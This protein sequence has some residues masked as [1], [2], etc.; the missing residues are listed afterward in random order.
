MVNAF[1]Y[2]T[3]VLLNRIYRPIFF[4]MRT[5]HMTAPGFPIPS[6]R[7]LS[8]DAYNQ[9]NLISNAKA[10]IQIIRLFGV[11]RRSGF[12]QKHIKHRGILFSFLK[13]RT[14]LRRWLICEKGYVDKCTQKKT[15]PRMF[16]LANMSI[17]S[18]VRYV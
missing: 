13:T 10:F 4:F 6:Y 18:R 5:H 12:S 9:H 2:Q 7:P 8:C 15:G 3:I 1:S 14:D 11:L 17:R 16:S